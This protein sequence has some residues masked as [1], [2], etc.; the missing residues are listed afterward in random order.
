MTVFL[1]KIYFFLHVWPPWCLFQIF[2]AHPQYFISV[3]VRTAIV[4]FNVCS[5]KCCNNEDTHIVNRK[6]KV[7]DGFV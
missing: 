1:K 2:F 7:Q 3:S 6:L 4:V 5:H